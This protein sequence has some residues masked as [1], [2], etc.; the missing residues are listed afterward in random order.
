MSVTL[1]LDSSRKHPIEQSEFNHAVKILGV[2]PDLRLGIYPTI[3]TQLRNLLKG[4]KINWDARLFSLHRTDGFTME[5]NLDMIFLNGVIAPTDYPTGILTLHSLFSSWIQLEIDEQWAGTGVA[6][7]LNLDPR[8]SF[9]NVKLLKFVEGDLISQGTSNFNLKSTW[10][11][12]NTWQWDQAVVDCQS[13]IPRW[14]DEKQF[15]FDHSWGKEIIDPFWGTFNFQ[16][17]HADALG[18]WNLFP[19]LSN[20]VLGMEQRFLEERTICWNYQSQR[21]ESSRWMAWSQSLQQVRFFQLEINLTLFRPILDCENCFAFVLAH[22]CA[23]RI[24]RKCLVL[25]HKL[26]SG[27]QLFIALFVGERRDFDWTLVFEDVVIV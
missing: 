9:L 20:L 12:E 19:A 8:H 6:Y 5:S 24:E 11:S 13:S 4:R 17:E 1:P 10:N 27:P 25:T 22:V 21:Q 2:Q 18:D 14:F 7:R 23:G 26:S 3:F 15:G 16:L